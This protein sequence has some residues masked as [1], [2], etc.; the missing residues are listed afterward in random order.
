V[1]L[2]GEVLAPDLL[3][4]QLARDPGRYVV[5]VA[6]P[7]V[8]VPQ[9]RVIELGAGESERVA[10]RVIVLPVGQTSPPEP[11]AT[12]EPSAAPAPPGELARAAQPAEEVHPDSTRRTAAWVAFGVGAAGVIGT[13]ASAI[14]RQPAYDAVTGNTGCH[15]T[16]GWIC[17]KSLQSA[18][19]PDI[20]TGNTASTLVNVFVTVAMVG[21]ATGIVLLATSHP[22]NAG[23]ALVLSPTGAWTMGT[24]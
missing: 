8:S 18:L 20:N 2:N 21:I 24:F 19:Q 23:A 10:L 4:T 6:G 14:V 3:G 16:N 13:V 1:R 15:D 17:D 11:S 7:R 22:R 5:R 12:V 9:E